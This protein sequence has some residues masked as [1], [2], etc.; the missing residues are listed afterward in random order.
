MLPSLIDVA[1]SAALHDLDANVRC[2]FLRCSIPPDAV[3]ADFLLLDEALRW[4]ISSLAARM[5][6]EF[7]SETTIPLLY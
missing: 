6:M 7:R 4:G 5:R 3:S 1:G 2:L